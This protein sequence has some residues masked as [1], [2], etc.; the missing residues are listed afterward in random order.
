MSSTTPSINPWSPKSPLYLDYDEWRLHRAGLITPNPNIFLKTPKMPKSSSSTRVLCFEITRKTLKLLIFCID[1]EMFKYALNVAKSTAHC[2]MEPNIENTYF[3]EYCNSSYTYAW[4]I[5][6]QLV[7][8]SGQGPAY[9]SF[10]TPITAKLSAGVEWWPSGAFILYAEFALMGPYQ[11]QVW[12]HTRQQSGHRQQGGR[13][14]LTS[15]LPSHAPHFFPLI[16]QFTIQ[17]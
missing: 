14:C 1:T 5:S 16:S 11:Q 6:L 2:T 13:G 8:S 4:A 7:A 12:V 15:K 3:I 10:Q 9:D 17:T